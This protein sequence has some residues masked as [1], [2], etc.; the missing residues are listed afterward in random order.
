[1]SDSNVREIQLGGKQLV[2]LFMASVV[3][4]VAIFL[5]GIPA[6]RALR[7]PAEAVPTEAAAT[8][9]PVGEMPPPTVTT[10]EDLG[11]HD[12]LQGQ[13]PPPPQPQPAE[14]EP[15]PA[16]PQPTES[17]DVAVAKPQGP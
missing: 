2:F 16:K 7:T 17:T 3:V 13:T 4:A 10:S 6:G 5:L 12:K 9:E 1:M 15:E 11:Y 14:P 8:D